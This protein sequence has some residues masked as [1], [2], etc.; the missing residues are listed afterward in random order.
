M[1]YYA[2]AREEFLDIYPDSARFV[3]VNTDDESFDGSVFAY[4]YDEK[5]NTDAIDKLKR[6]LDS[7]SKL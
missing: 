2:K 5:V 7:Y 4:S 3:T 6:I 1:I